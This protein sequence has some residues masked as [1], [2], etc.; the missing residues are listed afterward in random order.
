MAG[1]IRLTFTVFFGARGQNEAVRMT[2]APFLL[3][4]LAAVAPAC[5]GPVELAQ[6]HPIAAV[7]PGAA[8]AAAP[9][10]PSSTAATTLV[11]SYRGAAA[12][13]T[14]VVVPVLGTSA[15]GWLVGTPCGRTVSARNVPAGLSRRP[16][17]PP[18]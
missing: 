1:P 15:D 6:E 8:V 10:R 18:C 7:A 12:T 2:R 11:S 5:R 9:V 17:S 16:G 13:P 14:G 3:A 4:L